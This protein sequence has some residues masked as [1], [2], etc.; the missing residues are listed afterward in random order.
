[1]HDDGPLGYSTGDGLLT[2]SKSSRMIN[3][4]LKKQT[5]QR[6]EYVRDVSADPDDAEDD[7]G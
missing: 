6:R 2:I 1:L 7:E 5:N 3:A 4:F